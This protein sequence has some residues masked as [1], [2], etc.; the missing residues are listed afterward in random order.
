MHSAGSLQ[1]FTSILQIVCRY[2]ADISDIS[3]VD[4]D[5]NLQW[6]NGRISV[7]FDGY[8]SAV[9][10]NQSFASKLEKQILK[11]IRT[12]GIMLGATV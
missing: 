7:L 6:I 8:S 9:L 3:Q 11:R 12:R 5:K 10:L 2:S 4:S 1:T